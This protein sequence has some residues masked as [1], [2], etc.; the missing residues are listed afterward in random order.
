MSNSK[1][2]ILIIG[3]GLTGLT[4]NYFLKKDEKVAGQFDISLIEARNRI[5]GRIS[6]IEFGNAAN[7]IEM[8]A[9]WF[10]LKHKRFINL[11]DQLN[12]EYFEQLIGKKAYYEPLSTSPPYLVDLPP[13]PEPSLR[14]KG[15]TS[16]VINKL[17]S[18]VSDENIR[19]N[20][21]VLSVDYK[22]NSIT[23]KT[24]QKNI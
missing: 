12:I 20:E 22:L 16:Q 15:G 18:F 10:G 14:I 23:V 7:T 19:L 2:K 24:E 13:S 11:L 3:S 6:T 4:I 8:G 9:T 17:R 21:K 1:R 5:G